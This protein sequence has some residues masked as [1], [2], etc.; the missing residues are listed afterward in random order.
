[1]KKGQVIALLDTTLLYP[2]MLNAAAAV[3]KARVNVELTRLQFERIDTLFH[4]KVESKNDYD[5]SYEAYQAAKA[6]LQAAEATLDNDK[7]NLGYATI[8]APC[9]GT[10]ISRQVNVGQT[11][12]SSFNSPQLFT[13]GV[14]L[15]QM[16][17]LADVDEADIGQVKDG[18]DAAFTVDAYPYDIFRGKVVQI[19]MNPINIQ[20]VNNYVVVINAPNP[21]LKLLP[22]LTATTTI[23]TAEHDHVYRVLANAIH[24]TPPGDYLKHIKFPDAELAQIQAMKVAGNE[25][26]KPGSDCYLW[27]DRNDTLTPV[28]VTLGLFDGTLIEVSGDL[29]PGDNAVTGIGVAQATSTTSSNPFMPQMHPAANKK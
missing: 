17:D 18:Q 29:R 16:L 13:I 7:T 2:T 4:A 9:N 22:G 11:V 8:K 27:V 24:F 25:I 5:M 14:D 21:D 10:V 12:V 23:R 6:D 15:T 26:P 1:V 19:R 20:N 28:R 3:S